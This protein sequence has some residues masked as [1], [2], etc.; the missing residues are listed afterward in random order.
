MLSQLDAHTVRP[1]AIKVVWAVLALGL[2]ALI[3]KLVG[4]H[5]PQAEAWIGQQ[6]AWA[7]L[8]WCNE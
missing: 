3:G 5:I 6:G 4:A 7:P 8:V 1:I 2:L